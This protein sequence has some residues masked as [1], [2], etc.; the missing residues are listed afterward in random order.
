MSLTLTHLY[1][2]NLFEKASLFIFQALDGLFAHSS[3]SLI[4]LKVANGAV[5]LLQ[6]APVHFIDAY[7][8][9]LSQLLLHQSDESLNTDEFPIGQLLAAIVQKG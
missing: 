6:F 7:L 3:N 2:V 5:L 4:E 1:H 8:L 9:L